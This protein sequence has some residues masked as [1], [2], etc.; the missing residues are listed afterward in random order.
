MSNKQRRNKK[1]IFRKFAATAATTSLLVSPLAPAMNAV[2]DTITTNEAEINTEQVVEVP[3]TEFPEDVELPAD[4][5]VEEVVSET[6]TVE[7]NTAGDLVLPSV[8]TDFLVEDTATATE[9]ELFSREGSPTQKWRMIST[10]NP[11]NPLPS[12]GWGTIYRFAGEQPTTI[13]ITPG[14]LSDDAA[15]KALIF[16]KSGLTAQGA[17]TWAGVGPNDEN[18]NPSWVDIGVG[19]SV[20]NREN[21]KVVV[22][23]SDIETKGIATIR[24]VNGNNDVMLW[25]TTNDFLAHPERENLQ[26]APAMVEVAV[27][28][29]EITQD[30]I[31]NPGLGVTPA[32]A[33][34]LTTAQIA[35]MARLQ[36]TG[37][38][39]E[40]VALT[41]VEFEAEGWTAGPHTVGEVID[42]TFSVGGAVKAIPV[43]IVAEWP[44]SPLQE[45][46]TLGDQRHQENWGDWDQSWTSVFRLNGTNN[47]VVL[48]P[49]ELQLDNEDLEALILKRA[50]V[51]GEW[52]ELKPAGNTGI[53]FNA[54]FVPEWER[55]GIDQVGG[56]EEYAVRDKGS[57]NVDTSDIE[58]GKV[59]VSILN[60]NDN[61]LYD[62]D[63]SFMT[64]ALTAS[65]AAAGELEIEIAIVDI[66]SEELVPMTAE[67]FDN[68]SSD[69]SALKEAA[70]LVVSG[71]S[72][73]DVEVRV[74][75]GQV[76]EDS[77]SGVTRTD[78]E[79]TFSYNGLIKTTTIFRTL[80]FATT[81]DDS[82]D[83][84][85]QV[86]PVGEDGTAA[87]ISFNP[88]AISHDDLSEL[89][90]Q[91]VIEM[92]INSSDFRLFI[93]D[94]DGEVKEIEGDDLLA[95]IELDGD[96]LEMFM[97]TNR[98]FGG[99]YNI[100]Y[101]LNQDA[102]IQTFGITNFAESDVDGHI[103]VTVSG[104]DYRLT[105][106][107]EE[108]DINQ[109]EV[110]DND[111]DFKAQLLELIQPQVE[112]K[113]YDTEEVGGWEEHEATGDFELELPAG[114]SIEELQLD[115]QFD[116]TV[117]Y[118]VFADS[119]S[120]ETG[121]KVI[122]EQAKVTINSSMFSDVD[123][124][125]VAM[126]LD[127]AVDADWKNDV[128]ATATPIAMKGYTDLNAEIINVT[129]PFFDG[130]EGVYN[131]VF[132]VK[133]EGEKESKYIN[134][135]NAVT[136]ID[137]D[138]GRLAMSDDLR[139]FAVSNDP[140]LALTDIDEETIDETLA[141]SV[142]RVIQ[143]VDITTP[144]S[145]FAG[146]GETPRM[147]E[148]VENPALEFD[149]EELL[150]LD[151]AHEGLDVAFYFGPDEAEITPTRASTSQLPGNGTMTVAVTADELSGDTGDNEVDDETTN[152][153]D[154]IVTGGDNVDTGT[155]KN[156]P[157]TGEMAST[158]GLFGAALLG[159][160]GLTAWLKKR[161]NSGK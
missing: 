5:S 38:D 158:A 31:Q 141:D 19:S 133:I 113:Y 137:T 60:G 131:A 14:Q 96:D 151:T 94:A 118:T 139:H 122:T 82:E 104:Y 1:A 93:V 24:L 49:E 58:D 106:T 156:L 86:I 70:G 43:R 20:D 18:W 25:D 57:L 50:N 28:V 46:E 132:E 89:D 80:E 47:S 101:R 12:Q 125:R 27:S 95:V 13:N 51:Y 110:A 44:V 143:A 115:E 88:T 90:E 22:D 75:E 120:E 149:T 138:G 66:S 97:N 30:W 112:R 100:G 54:D 159:L 55:F 160:S 62:V 147:L 102:L 152:G 52:A 23:T 10:D 150:A 53:S 41:D 56:K 107:E 144:V 7:E 26:A 79:V 69:D 74:G 92:I 59:K 71:I 153:D 145:R 45:W 4:E 39:D 87:I 34:T 142:T 17:N 35:D 81:T 33:S 98:F 155:G 134:M 61:L 124:E 63:R 40:T 36:F 21:A 72:E 108:V 11:M 161:R 73:A 140:T 15:L 3:E 130:E 126:S 29:G 42:V 136:I 109:N 103:P 67:A 99:I 121:S 8:S 114:F 111:T 129:V 123:A 9:F 16:E 85:Q 154:T 6:P 37:A 148:E 127:E 91:E 146:N 78:Y 68:I 84:I 64:D 48:T 83:T 117:S 128:F 116:V 2:A 135:E 119:D 77:G 32:E 105:L 157:S 76:T 65:H